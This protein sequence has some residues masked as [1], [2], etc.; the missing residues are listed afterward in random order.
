MATAT[1]NSRMEQALARMEAREK[2]MQPTP[3]TLTLEYVE[4]MYRQL[5]GWG[6][7][8]PERAHSLE[9]GIMHCFIVNVV[10]KKYS[11]D[12]ASA[13][14]EVIVKINKLSFPRWFS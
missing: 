13:I 2:R 7:E 6:K 14:G 4:W 8:D 11:E 3:E 10:A 1:D 12:Q 5:E 9:K